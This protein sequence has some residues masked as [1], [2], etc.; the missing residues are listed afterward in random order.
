MTQGFTFWNLNLT[1]SGLKVEVLC[2][3]ETLAHSQNALNATR[4]KNLD[5]HHLNT[6]IAVFWVVAPCSLVW[7]NRPD[8]GGSKVL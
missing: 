8:D 2:P 3:S 4:H 5:D 6:K 1:S 7:T